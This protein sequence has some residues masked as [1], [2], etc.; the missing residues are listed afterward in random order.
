MLLVIAEFLLTFP[1]F[2]VALDDLETLRFFQ[3]HTNRHFLTA[4]I[5]FNGFSLAY[6][7]LLLHAQFDVVD[8]LHVLELLF[9]LNIRNP[10]MDNGFGFGIELQILLG[11]FSVYFHGF[12][13][14]LTLLEPFGFLFREAQHLVAFLSSTA[15]TG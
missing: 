5:Q 8:F 12:L 6:L 4:Y 13:D 7:L 11:L 15:R 1:L 9:Q 10:A 2:H 14:D 3:I